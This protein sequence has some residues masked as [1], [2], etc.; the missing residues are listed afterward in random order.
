MASYELT[1]WIVFGV[2]PAIITIAV[3]WILIKTL[4][5]GRHLRKHGIEAE[6]EVYKTEFQ[7]GEYICYIRYLGDDNNE[8]LSKLNSKTSIPVGNVIKIKFL[9]GQYDD[10]VTAQKQ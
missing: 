1:F 4:T 5:A 6:G 10:I 9:S 2:L 7:D 3:W 8:H